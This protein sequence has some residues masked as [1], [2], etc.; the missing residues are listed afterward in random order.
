M[1]EK[2]QMILV[3]TE[4]PKNLDDG[5]LQES[6]S[7]PCLPASDAPDLQTE[8]TKNLDNGRGPFNVYVDKIWSIFDH[9]PTSM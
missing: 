2:K 7:P 4:E 9:L 5:N 1:S 3:E 6:N 8:E